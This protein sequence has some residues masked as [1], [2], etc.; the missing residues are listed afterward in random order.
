MSNDEVVSS[1]VSPVVLVIRPTWSVLARSQRN[2]S[3]WAIMNRFKRIL[4]RLPIP[5][6]DDVLDKFCLEPIERR[7]WTDEVS[8]Q[9]FVQDQVGRRMTVLDGHVRRR[10]CHRIGSSSC[11]R[12]HFQLL[13]LPIAVILLYTHQIGN[14]SSLPKRRWL[15]RRA[16][17][18]PTYEHVLAL[19]KAWKTDQTRPEQM[20]WITDTFSW[21]KKFYHFCKVIFGTW[22][23][24]LNHHRL[25]QTPWNH[26]NAAPP[27]LT[28]MTET[29]TD[30]QRQR[31]LNMMI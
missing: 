20:V 21:W 16:K 27:F 8:W 13:L 29:E 9:H 11:L 23:I 28:E 2:S 18:W 17:F 6:I 24:N 5:T 30:R 22:R 19:K 1:D 3:D 15:Y 4:G 31:W 7:I 12:F 14:A 25:N 10:G 26:T